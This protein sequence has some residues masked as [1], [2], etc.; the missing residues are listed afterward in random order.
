MP[1]VLKK[2]KLVNYKIFKTDNDEKKLS[3]YIKSL[4]FAHFL[5][6]QNE[7]ADAIFEKFIKEFTLEADGSTSYREYKQLKLITQFSFNRLYGETFII[8]NPEFQNLKINDAYTVMA[9]GSK[10]ITPPNA[11]MKFCREMLPFQPQLIT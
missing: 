2:I 6:S 9:D 3:D 11:L 10:V 5:F 1:V 8:Y 7:N 4:F